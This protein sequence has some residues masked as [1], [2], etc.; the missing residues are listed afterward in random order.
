MVSLS[1]DPLPLTPLPGTLL[2]SAAE[3][4]AIYDA[5]SL[6]KIKPEPVE[7][8]AGMVSWL[9]GDGNA[10]DIVDS[11]HGSLVGGVTFPGGMVDQAFSLDG[12]PGTRVSI[13]DSAQPAFC[14]KLYL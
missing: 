3:I 12:A 9:P 14:W 6:G 8:P 4:K 2:L 13:P 11:N 1:P 7:P 5:G 10:Q